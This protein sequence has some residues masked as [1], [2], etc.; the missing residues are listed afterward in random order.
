MDEIGGRVVDSY[1]VVGGVTRGGYYLMVFFHLGFCLLVS[2]VLSLF[3]CE[4]SMIAVVSVCLFII[5]F[6]TLQS[7][8]L[9]VIGR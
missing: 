3:L 5:S 6:L 7:L 2:H 8:Y 1:Q 4:Q 9:G